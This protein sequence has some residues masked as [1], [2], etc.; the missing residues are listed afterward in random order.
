MV[1]DTDGNE[2]IPKAFVGLLS[3]VEACTVG[4]GAV[5]LYENG[6]PA[7][8]AET[9]TLEYLNSAVKYVVKEPDKVRGDPVDESVWECRLLRYVYCGSFK[10]FK[11]VLYGRLS[12]RTKRVLR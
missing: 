3:G 6:D 8:C 12:G 2:T 5:N 7:G 4:K 11:C 9:C 1:K 10:F